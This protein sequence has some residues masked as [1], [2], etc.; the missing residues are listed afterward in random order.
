MTSRIDYCGSLLYGLLYCLINKLQRVQ[1][2][3]AR[4]IFRPKFSQITPLIYE[5]HWLPIGYRIQ[6]KI[7]LI[8]FKSV[9]FIAPFYLSSMISLRSPPKYNLRPSQDGLLLSYPRFRSKATLGDHSFTCSVP[10]L[11][12]ALPLVIRKADTVAIFMLN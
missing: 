2:A 5:L 12:N 7:L 8:T 10:K 6:F 3:C 4:L 9:K 11:W 1:N